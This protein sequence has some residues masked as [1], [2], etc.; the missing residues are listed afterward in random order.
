[1]KATCILTALLFALTASAQPTAQEW[2][3]NVVG[4]NLGNQLECSAPGQ[5]GESMHIGMVDN[6]IKAETAWGNPVVTKKVIKAVKD[7]GFN[8]IR[9]PIRWQC[10]ITNDKAMSIDKAWMARVKEVIDWCLAC[11]LKVIIN[12]HHDKWLEGRPFQQYKDENCQ[13]LA[14]LWFNIANAF[15]SYDYRLAFAGTNEVHVKDNWGK[16]TAENLEVQNAYNQTFI[17]I[18][19]ATGGNNLQRHLITQTYV[20]NPDFGLY[21]NDFIVPKDVEGNGNK[22]MSVEFHYYTPWD[23]AGECKYNFWGEDFKQ[24]GEAS[25][26]N[27]KTMTEFFDKVVNTWASLGL[28]IVMG[29]WGVTDRQSSGQ[30]DRIH[31]NMTYYCKFLVSE[32]RKRGFST[33]IWDNNNFGSGPEH[34]GIFDRK[35]S[36]KVKAPWILQGIMEGKELKN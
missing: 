16:P 14:L 26:S 4:W 5:D 31:E 30:T 33:F 25:P 24:Y 29:E 20:C 22:Y 13:K 3:K 15:A 2:N 27:E 34:F 10:H 9:I 35:G 18:V 1:M 8:A 7:A 32:T 19:R 23:Y 6:S 17:D 12:V 28:G 36:M 11:D 21:N